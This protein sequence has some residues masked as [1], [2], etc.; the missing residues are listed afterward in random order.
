MPKR[1][2]RDSEGTDG[3]MTDDME[4]SCTIAREWGN[5]PVY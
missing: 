3:R 5:I 1:P 4:A 2:G